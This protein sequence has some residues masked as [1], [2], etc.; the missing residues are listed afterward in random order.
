MKMKVSKT[1]LIVIATH[2][3][4]GSRRALLGGTAEGAVEPDHHA[5][6]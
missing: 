1:H 5:V 6:M 2:G 4:T 3:Y